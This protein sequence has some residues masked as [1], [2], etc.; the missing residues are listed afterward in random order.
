MSDWIIV[1][2]QTL[3]IADILLQD[4]K[5]HKKNL[6]LSNELKNPVNYES[7]SSLAATAETTA[8]TAATTTTTAIITS[9]P[10]INT[11]IFSP[12]PPFA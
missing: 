9:S 2:N 7:I 11:N 4:S 6:S 8:D 5:I 1:Y 12:F 3:H 10:P